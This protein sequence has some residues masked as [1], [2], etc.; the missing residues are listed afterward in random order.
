MG[1]KKTVQFQHVLRKLENMGDS[2][3]P[4]MISI[5]HA[6]THNISHNEN[7][8]SCE[9]KN[10]D[11]C[12]SCSI[13]N[14]RRDSSKSNTGGV[15][16]FLL[17]TSDGTCVENK[18]VDDFRKTGNEKNQITGRDSVELNDRHISVCTLNIVVPKVSPR[19]RSKICSDKDDINLSRAVLSGQP[20]GKVRNNHKFECDHIIFNC[21]TFADFKFYLSYSCCRRSDPSSA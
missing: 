7:T 17:K 21:I 19:F 9:R 4:S 18:T 8:G 3:V 12:S 6:N 2:I 15:S 5:N 10:Y 20:W 1:R 11:R 16:S 14:I 13:E